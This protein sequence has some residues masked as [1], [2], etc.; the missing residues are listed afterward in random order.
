[1]VYFYLPVLS[2]VSKHTL[3]IKLFSLKICYK[4]NQDTEVNWKIVISKEGKGGTLEVQ[5][6]QGPKELDRGLAA[7]A[8]R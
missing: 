2:I 7:Q 6:N 4:Q 1:M 8:T 5:T 3:I